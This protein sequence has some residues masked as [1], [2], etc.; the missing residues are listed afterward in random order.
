MKEKRGKQHSGYSCK[1][2]S[3][4]ENMMYQLFWEVLPLCYCQPGWRERPYASVLAQI[5][6][7]T[8]EL[9]HRLEAEMFLHD[10]HQVIGLERGS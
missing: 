2:L 9:I 1:K 6:A 4:S 10:H 3:C 7:Q 5:Q 8:G